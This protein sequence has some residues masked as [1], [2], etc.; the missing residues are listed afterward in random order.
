MIT[1][2]RFL[3]A[4]CCPRF[5]LTGVEGVRLSTVLTVRADLF[6]DFDQDSFRIAKVEAPNA[7]VFS[8]MRLVDCRN[9][10]TSHPFICA[11]DVIDG[12]DKTDIIL[13]LCLELIGFHLDCR[14]H[15]FLAKECQAVTV[16]I[17]VCIGPILLTP[18]HREPH[19]I[20]IEAEARLEVRDQESRVCHYHR[21]NSIHVAKMEAVA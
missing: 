14:S 17:E 10:I 4:I 7:P 16:C 6:I 20:A 2:K 12:E 13:L 18:L 1:K 5:K 21:L 3:N 15:R 8:I 11:I 9:T 19:G